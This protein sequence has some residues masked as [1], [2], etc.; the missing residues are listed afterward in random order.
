MQELDDNA[1]LREYAEHDSQEAFAA[2]VARH[3]NKVYS[4]ALRHTGDPNRA[5]EIT[6]AV[7]TILAKK[8]RSLGRD[9]VISGWLYQTARLTARTLIRGEIRRAQRQQEA[10]MQ[11]VSNQSEPEIWAEIAPQLDA[12]MEELSELDRHAVVLRF[13]D[14]RSMSDVGAAL[15]ATEEAAKKR[16]TRAVEKLR[17]FFSRRGVVLTA[18]VL[19]STIAAHSVQAAPAMLAKSVAALAVTQGAAAT[20]STL[21]LIKGALKVMA[22]TKAKTAIGIAIVMVVGAGGVVV[23][24]SYFPGEPS[25]EGRKLLEWL[26]DV[27][28]RQPQA[29]RAKAAEAIRHMGR[30]TL[31]FLLA[32]LGDKRFGTVHYAEQDNR[33]KDERSRQATWAFDA[34]G[35]MGTSAIPEL[36]RLLEQNPGYAPVALADIGPDALPELLNAL[37]NGSFWV[38]DNTAVGLVNAIYS[39][40]IT[41]DQAKAAFPIALNNLTYENTNTLFRDNTRWRATSLLAALKRE[42]EITV[43]ALLRGLDDTNASVAAA[44]IIAL[45]AFGKDARAA[46]PALEKAADSTNSLL[47]PVAKASLHGIEP[48]KY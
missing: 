21:S 48:S 28:Y 13:F 17:L 38:R 46:I 24:N 6:Q 20:G 7:F 40:K 33:S 47:S 35:T 8:S 36:K 22:W 23:K 45:G 5:E 44:Y 34:L 31:P 9:V 41:S 11:N 29:K 32:D 19:T 26:A 10:L 3:V 25:Y 14:G 15:G 27:D 42:P 2:L 37:T 16:V 39:G 4:V 18:G 30:K 43:P 12:A 1:L